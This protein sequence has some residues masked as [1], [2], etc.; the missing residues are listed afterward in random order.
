MKSTGIY[1]QFDGNC[2]KAFTFYKGVFNTEFLGIFRY[3]DIPESSNMPA[4]P[5]KDLDKIENVSIR[6]NEHF[7]LMGSDIPPFGG[8]TFTKG[9]NF[10]IYLE[11]D[12]Q[13]EAEKVFSGLSQS[14]TTVMP[15]QTA[16]WGGLFGMCTDK[17][18]I[19]W[20]INFSDKTLSY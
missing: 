14:G 8:F 16:H 17:F 12:S 20:M 3:R 9:N 18:G 19:N 4:V 1:L 13:E 11:A 6:I 7:I 5:E 2:E 10:S 15:L